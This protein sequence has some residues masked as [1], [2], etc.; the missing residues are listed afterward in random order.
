MMQNKVVYSVQPSWQTVS[1]IYRTEL[2]TE[3]NKEKRNKKQI[4]ISSVWGLTFDSSQLMF[5][6]TSKSCDTKTRPNIKNPARTT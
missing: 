6:P 3:K 4:K 5:V 2:E 1:L